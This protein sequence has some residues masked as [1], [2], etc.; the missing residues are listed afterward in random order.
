MINLIEGFMVRKTS[1]QN[2]MDVLSSFSQRVGVPRHLLKRLHNFGFEMEERYDIPYD[3]VA[4]VG[5]PRGVSLHVSTC[6]KHVSKC[7]N[8]RALESLFPPFAVHS[9]L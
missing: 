5:F 7:E 6:E 1:F 3:R 2:Y 8:A 9:T 4:K